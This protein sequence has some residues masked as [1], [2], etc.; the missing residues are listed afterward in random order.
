MAKKRKPFRRHLKTVQDLITTPENTRAG[1][2]ALALERN[3]RASPYVAEGRDLKVNAGQVSKPLQLRNMDR[4]QAALLTAAGV[5]DKAARHFLE[6]DK[7]V[8]IENLITE[9]LEPAGNLFLEELLFRFLLTRGATLGGSM[10]NIGGVLAQRKFSRALMASLTNAGIAFRWLHGP[11]NNWAEIPKSGT[12][13]LE[14]EMRG[15]TWTKGNQSRTLV[16]N[17]RVPVV[18]NN[19]DL[20]LFDCSE[21]DYQA[22]AFRNAEQYLVL[23]ELKGGIDPAGADEHWK[24]AATALARIRNAFAK[25]NC[26]PLIFFVAAAIAEKMAR[27]I[28]EQLEDGRLA[29]AANLTTDDQVAS[30]CSWLCDL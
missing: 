12:S 25:E 27:E 17:L 7:K 9:F 6:E 3:H 23:G 4:I 22:G 14:A 16:F 11:T 1:F 8:A 26:Q 29:N 30:V 13:G 18:R 10:R 24:T 19:V 5:S 20:C 28:W 21:A 15:L 2:I